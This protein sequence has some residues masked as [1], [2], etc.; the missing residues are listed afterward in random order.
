MFKVTLL[1]HRSNGV[2][3][4]ITGYFTAGVVTFNEISVFFI[5]F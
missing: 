1:I 5:T 2:L 4:H 3:N